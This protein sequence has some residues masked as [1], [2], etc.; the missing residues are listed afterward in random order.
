[1]LQIARFDIEARTMTKAARNVN[2][3][4]G[5]NDEIASNRKQCQSV[6]DAVASESRLAPMPLI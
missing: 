4:A 6:F 2:S 3:K 1:M 5:P